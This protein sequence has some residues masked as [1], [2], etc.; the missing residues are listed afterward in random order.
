MENNPGYIF[1]PY[2]LINN[3]NDRYYSYDVEVF[4]YNDRIFYSKDELEITKNRDELLNEISNGK[5]EN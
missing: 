5:I 3:I 2:I 4:I 1:V